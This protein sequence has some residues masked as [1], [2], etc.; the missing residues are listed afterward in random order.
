MSKTALL[1]ASFAGIYYSGLASI[2]SPL[3]AGVGH[4]FCLHHVCPG[5]GEQSGFAP[6][7]HLE[8]SPEFLDR[9]I[10]TMKQKDIALVSLDEALARLRSPGKPQQRFAVFTLD[11][12]Y[13]DN[14]LHALPVF[15]RHN[16]PFTVYVAP[17]IAE[18]TCELWWRLLEV[19][20]AKSNEVAVDLAGA[21]VVLSTPD[22][23]SK[24]N[25]WS[26]LAPKIQAM[27]EYKQREVI[28][29]LCTS[30]NVDW[31]AYCREVAMTWDELR[32]LA[33]HP[34]ATI[35]AHTLNH[36]NLL[37]LSAADAEF[38]IRQSKLQIEAQLGAPVKHFAYPYG[39][40]DAAGP[41]EF[42]LCKAAGFQ[43]AVVTRL[44]ALW[45]EHA[46]HVHALPRIMI[47]GRYQSRSAVEALVSGVPAMLANKFK[48]LN[49]N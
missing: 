13:R 17:R 28:R 23:A 33:K 36:Y 35:G 6:N 8:V 14:A 12:G 45:P 4:I 5:G 27:D 39:N 48:R 9:L 29:T 19:V 30:Y 18:G 34:L 37:K 42:E 25:A 31:M 10:L 32:L 16:C 22:T 1:R 47:S 46:D 41:R 49:V 38:E 7:T 43:S 11:D 15:E 26:I 40:V 3:T 44:G 21:R 2:L 24:A 20:I